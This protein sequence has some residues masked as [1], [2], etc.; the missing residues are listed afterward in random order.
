MSDVMPATSLQPTIRNIPLRFFFYK[1]LV[2]ITAIHSVQHSP[3]H[4]HMTHT[5]SSAFD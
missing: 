5:L 1:A 4:F 2:L 3:T